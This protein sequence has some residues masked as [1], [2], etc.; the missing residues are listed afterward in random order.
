MDF[1]LTD[2][3]QQY[4]KSL[5]DFLAAEIAPHA[6]ALDRTETFRRENLAALARFGFT[7]LNFPEEYGGTGADLLTTTM[8][9]IELARA[10]AA[11]ALSVGASLALCGFP[12]LKHGTDEQRRRY[13]PRLISGASI[14]ALALTEP[15]AGS[16]L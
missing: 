13:L 10:C 16:D 14:G 8:A 1:G 11:T 12:I 4:M 2:E 6:S 5:G 7:G 15:G 3:Q 9:S